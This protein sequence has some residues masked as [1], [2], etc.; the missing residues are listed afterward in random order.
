MSNDEQ[1]Y[2]GSTPLGQIRNRNEHR[3][4]KMLPQVL[5]QY[6]DF[7]SDSID[8][9]DIYAL[10]LNKLPAHYVQETA[11]VLQEVVD[12]DAVLQAL[13]DAVQMVRDKPN[14]K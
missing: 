6:D 12:D 9:Q 2:Y 14:H 5:G 7:A 3:V 8:I 10:A 13:K 4:I 11:I 1:Y